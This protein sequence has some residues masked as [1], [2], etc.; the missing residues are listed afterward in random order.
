MKLL[1]VLLLFVFS[2]SFFC[3]CHSQYQFRHDEDDVQQERSPIKE[4]KEVQQE[5]SPI[6]ES[7]EVQQERSLIKESKEVQQE[8]SLI[9]E[10]LNNKYT[11]N[12]CKKVFCNAWQRCVG[13]N[14]ICKLPYQCPK[15]TT[16]VC[17][18]KGRTF[19]NY[20]QLKAYEC[21]HP[22]EKFRSKSRCITSEKF[23]VSLDY[24]NS[25]SEGLIQVELVNH[26]EKLFVCNEWSMNEANVV[27]VHLGFTKGAEHHEK[28]FAVPE[29]A[30]TSSQCLHATCRGLETSLAECALIKRPNVN[31]NRTVAS[32]VCH[33]KDRECQSN[34]FE[35]VNK[36]CIPLTETCNGINDCG[37]LSDEL[38]CKECKNNSF[39]CNSDVCIPKKYVCNKEIDCLAGEDESRAQCGDDQK[40]KPE[41]PGDQKPTRQFLAR[42]SIEANYQALH[43][44]K[45]NP[46]IPELSVVIPTSNID[47]ER[48][49]FKTL[50]P[51]LNC[52]VTSHPLTRRKR[53]IGGNT[54]RKGEFPWQVAIREGSGA[55]NCG[56]IYIGG[57][58]IL[59]A[60][61]CV[62]Q[63]RV[64]QYLIWTA[65]LDTI[66]FNN[67]TNT[68]RVNQVIIH[69]NYN[70]SNYQ[71]DIALLEIKSNDRGKPCSLAHSIPA[72]IPW[73]EYLFQAGHQCKVSGW[74]LAEGYTKQFVLRWGNIHLFPNC[75]EIYKERFFKEMECAGT[76]DGSIDSCKGDSGGPL[77]CLDSNNRAYVW[78]IVSW[79]ENCGVQGYPGVYTKVASYFEWISRHVGRSLISVYNI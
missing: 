50:L 66:H 15:N 9:K 29:S 65:I 69:E 57:C 47:E 63:S 70:A 74:G 41:D 37:D 5:R 27:C 75:S 11:H 2:W 64:N 16:S 35:C 30:S 44:Q 67:E 60:A 34:E 71:N 68:F 17:S 73:S 58:W 3:I 54:A 76:F 46:E 62:R 48:K 25:Q 28:M 38:C 22:Q 14:C 21:Q 49:K 32:I 78:G 52:G 4:S 53:I 10:C 59:T 12:S 36:K 23:E 79:G 6:K 55:V 7:K 43:E 72:C 61:H 8:R 51:H 31:S 1:L 26:T 45:P 40:P 20:C 18:T 33:T 19:H 24:A 77:V 13:G 56:G 39:H 42:T